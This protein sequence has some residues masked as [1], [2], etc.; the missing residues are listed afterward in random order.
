[1]DELS[2]TI[3]IVGSLASIIALFISAPNWRSRAVHVA[4][5]LVITAISAIAFEYRSESRDVELRLERF[6]K[7]EKQAEILLRLKPVHKDDAG[8]SQGFMLAA[9]TFLE[10]NKDLFPETYERAK[11][12]CKSHACTATG[13]YNGKSHAMHFNAMSAGAR[14][15]RTLIKGIIPNEGK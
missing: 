3:G 6:E 4:Y 15:M 7:V 13:Y 8:F 12:L 2:I 10:K 1:M 9:L 14:A 5:A 11:L